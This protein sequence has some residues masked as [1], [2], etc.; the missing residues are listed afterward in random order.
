MEKS[1]RKQRAHIHDKRFIVELNNLQDEMLLTNIIKNN[2]N[3]IYAII[4]SSKNFVKN[5]IKLFQK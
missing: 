4:N 3:V 1:S 2:A 5:A